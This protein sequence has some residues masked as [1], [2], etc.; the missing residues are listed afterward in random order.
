M[1]AR[2]I[3]SVEDLKHSNLVESR[4]AMKAQ[5]FPLDFV[6]LIREEEEFHHPK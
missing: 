4:I 6:K 3:E 2:R 1:H 5:L